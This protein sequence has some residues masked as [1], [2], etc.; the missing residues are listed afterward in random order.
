MK[1][2]KSRNILSSLFLDYTMQSTSVANRSND[3]VCCSNSVEPRNVFIQKKILM[4]AFNLN[5]KFKLNY[6]LKP[7]YRQKYILKKLFERYLNKKLILKKQGFSGY[8][9]EIINKTKIKREFSKKVKNIRKKSI[10][11]YVDKKNFY[12]DLSWKIANEKMF[13]KKFFLINNN[14]LVK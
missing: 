4:T 5:L 14:Y 13:L 10:K 6:K 8:P 7:I 3:L 1:C 11:N 2:A 12:R 9:E